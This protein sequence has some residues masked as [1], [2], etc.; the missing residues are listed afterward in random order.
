MA[1]IFTFD[2]DPPRVSSP[3]STPREPTSKVAGARSSPLTTAIDKIEE[4][5]LSVEGQA[6][7]LQAE[8]QEGPTEYKLHL[9]LRPRRSFSY[10]ST[11]NQIPGSY[12]SAALV[13]SD[14]KRNTSRSPSDTSMAKP[15]CPA[16]SSHTYQHRLQQLTTQLLWRL[17]QSSPYHATASHQTPLSGMVAG[18]FSASHSF[19]FGSLHPGLEDSKGALY[20]IGV[21]DDG[22]LVGLAGD[23]MDESL[24][25]LRTMAASLGCVVEVLR[26]VHV[27]DCE[28][29]EKTK[30]TCQAQNI[31]QRSKLWVA[32]AHVKPDTTGRNFSQQVSTGLSRGTEVSLTRPTSR[33]SPDTPQMRVTL[34]G[35]T[36]SGKTSLLGTLANSTLDNGRGKSRLSLLKHQHEMASGVTSSVAQ[37]LIGYTQCNNDEENE[38]STR[39]V[40]CASD[41]VSSWSDIHASSRSR[42]VFFLDSAGHSRYRRT[43]LRSLVG[44]APHWT[45]LCVAGEE[46]KD[47][48]GEKDQNISLPKDSS[49]HSSKV[50][51][52]NVT[53]P[54]L[55]LCLELSKP[56]IIVIC[57]LDLATKAKLKQMLAKLLSTVKNA[58]RKPILLSEGNGA[59]LG[60]GT[61]TDNEVQTVSSTDLE[62]VRQ[63]CQNM[64]GNFADI[65]PIVFTS[66]VRGTGIGKLHALLSELPIPSPIVPKATESFPTVP[67]P[68]HLF[69]VDDCF[70]FSARSTLENSLLA[71][72]DVTMDGLLIL[73]GYVQNGQIHAGMNLLLG[74]FLHS[75]MGSDFESGLKTGSGK[76]VEADGR[77]PFHALNSVPQNDVGLDLGHKHSHKADQEWRRVRITSVRTLRVPARTL[78]IDQVG[79]VG[80][81]AT[82]GATSLD[83]VRKGMVLIGLS[84]IDSNDDATYGSRKNTTVVPPSSQGCVARIPY[85]AHSELAPSYTVAANTHTAKVNYHDD[86]EEAAANA[87][88]LVP[89]SDA[90]LYFASVRAAAKVVSVRYE[91]S[92]YMATASTQAMMESKRYVLVTFR[93][94][95]MSEFVLPG[96]QI[97]IIPGGG[98]KGGA[99]GAG[100][101]LDGHVGVLVERI[102][103]QNV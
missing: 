84:D 13:S 38:S 23:E 6:H 41:G 91:D 24:R 61:V 78:H 80:V 21:S 56:T 46:F 67:I 39:I 15:I 48:S 88:N 30:S 3:W 34:V 12:H 64:Q 93:F 62:G 51:D 77:A 25:M 32:E 53:G 18:S 60:I 63:L 44:W 57:K 47:L 71:R 50:P 49:V 4:F 96:T 102:L 16:A 1:S 8:P 75:D 59:G 95:T 94:I 10:M 37:E 69:Y 45:L 82:D 98:G 100:S 40:N 92:T 54:Y 27:G 72:Q 29:V 81:V 66:A 103:H 9:L 65:V 89:G 5:S 19:E 99:G 42:L 55:K 85:N 87:L 73:S 33:E 97:L 70:D 11:I 83:R 43:A 20:E 79:T 101:G 90:L 28:W 14:K 17:Q 31:C 22:T 86:D 58:G 68:T 36:M 74:P 26:M 52:H 7:G 2:P 35:A 76:N